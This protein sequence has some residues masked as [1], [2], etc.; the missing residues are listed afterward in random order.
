MRKRGLPAAVLALLLVLA[1]AVLCPADEPD[2]DTFP[3]WGIRIAVPSGAE[4]VLDA[5]EGNYYI[6]PVSSGSI[7]YVMVRPYRDA[8]SARELVE[9]VFIDHMKETYPDLEITEDPSDKN[10]GGRD[11]VAVS[12]SYPV[13]ENVVTDR[14]LFCEAG[15]MVYMFCAKEAEALGLTVGSLLEDTVAAC[16][17]LSET[18]TEGQP[19]GTEGQPGGTEGQPGGTE[20][21]P[22]GTEGQPGG[23]DTPA[24]IG[25]V[26]SAAGGKTQGQGP[27]GDGQ[28]QQ[29]QDSNP[30]P[31]G[32]GQPQPGRDSNPEPG[33]DGQP[34]PGQGRTETS[35]SSLAGVSFSEWEMV[36]ADEYWNV[37]TRDITADDGGSYLMTY[38][39][40]REGG[41]PIYTYNVIWEGKG[42]QRIYTKDP[43]DLTIRPA[44]LFPIESMDETALDDIDTIY[45]DRITVSEATGSN[46]ILV[47]RMHGGE[48]EG[49][50]TT[51]NVV[52]GMKEFNPEYYTEL[53]SIDLLGVVPFRPEDTDKLHLGEL[54]VEDSGSS[55]EIRQHLQADVPNGLALVEYRNSS[56]KTVTVTEVIADGKGLV[57]AYDGADSP[58]EIK[59]GFFRVVS[60]L[61]SE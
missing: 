1:S 23:T 25:G 13:G 34:Q 33:G 15:G 54:Q 29:G 44:H 10:I 30:E 26:L 5:S 55:Y 16:E 12:F 45:T 52:N 41:D 17:F 39:E 38:T 4:G 56:G 14:R 60:F 61:G 21:Q 11:C 59:T 42:L 22:G 8:S 19:G 27:G 48:D 49:R 20:G 18:G 43:A 3:D 47:Y 51:G 37:Y 6:Y 31:G 46:F 7:P 9:N 36:E 28:P 24:D 58:L 32:D 35:G 53:E 2:Y 50:I 40:T 57:T